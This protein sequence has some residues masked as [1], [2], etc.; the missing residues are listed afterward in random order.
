M[1]EFLR[2]EMS[3]NRPETQRFLT[4]QENHIRPSTPYTKVYIVNR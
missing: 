1:V 3:L 4:I 2:D